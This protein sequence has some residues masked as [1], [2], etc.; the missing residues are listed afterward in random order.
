MI[1]YNIA[2]N[3]FALRLNIISKVYNMLWWNINVDK[4]S[5]QFCNCNQIDDNLIKS[6]VIY[7]PENI[8]KNYYW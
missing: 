4:T 8:F 5:T 3:F 2:R 7:I 1:V 6:L